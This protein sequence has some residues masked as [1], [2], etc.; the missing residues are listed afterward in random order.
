MAGEIIVAE[1]GRELRFTFDDLARFHGPGSPGGLAHGFQM[2]RRALPALDPAAPCERREIVVATAFGGPG[3]RDAIE[4]VTRAVSDGRFTL[5]PSLARPERGPTYERFVFR[6]TYRGTA[7]TLAVRDGFVP[8]E[9]IE[10]ARLHER[11]PEQDARLTAVKR[12]TADLVLAVP[13]ADV[14]DITIRHP[15]AGSPTT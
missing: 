7:V 3:A 11:S 4:M 8:G 2:L 14:Y 15:D 1:A 10:L 9:L 6:L 5:D 12:E 13:A